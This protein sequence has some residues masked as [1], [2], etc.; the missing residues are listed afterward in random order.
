MNADADPSR[1]PWRDRLHEIIFEADTPE[2]K[3]F[4]VVL[5][6]AIGLSVAAVSL[7]SVESYRLQHGRALVIAEWVFTILFTV[8][9]VLRLMCVR[10]PMG[11]A[12]SF[13]GIVDLLA[14]L[15]T[16]VSVLF[17]GAQ[18]LAVVRALRLLRI[19][20][21]FKLARYLSE[22]SALRAALVA[23][24]AKITVFLTTVLII[25]V[26]MGSV[27]HLIEG[28][29]NDGFSSIPQSVYWS[30]VTVTTVGYG[31]ATPETPVGKAL[32]ALMMIIGYSLIIV[33]G[34]IVSAQWI[35]S[36]RG[37]PITTQSCPTCSLEGHDADADY[38]KHCGGKL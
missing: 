4:D 11:Y 23:C 37:N 19:F 30:I 34:G 7:D 21:I 3:L 12:R 25:V 32:A 28:P 1:A 38:C 9:Y 26:I 2:G 29:T 5:L 24:R 31:K 8:E 15:P 27:M 6:I 16:Y 18:S 36:G 10:R 17:P 22:A 14:I 33:P 20:R 13:F 35:Q